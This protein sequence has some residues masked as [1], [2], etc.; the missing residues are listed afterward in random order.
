MIWHRRRHH[1]DWAPHY[2][3]ADGRW[4]IEPIAYTVPCDGYL[5]GHNGCPGST[6]HTREE[7]QL[8]EKFGDRWV[9]DEEFYPRLRDAKSVADQN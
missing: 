9:I 6:E 3:S 7:W 1:P 8:S 4:K 2:E 5:D